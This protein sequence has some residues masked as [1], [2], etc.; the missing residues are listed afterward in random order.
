MTAQSHEPT[1][2]GPAGSPGEG[3]FNKARAAPISAAMLADAAAI[4]AIAM[5]CPSSSSVPDR[6][7]NGGDILHDHSDPG[8]KMIDHLKV[9]RGQTGHRVA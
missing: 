2:S 4:S 7:R 8:A 5:R 6:E 3:Y 1:F 9:A